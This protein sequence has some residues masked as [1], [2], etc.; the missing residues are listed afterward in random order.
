MKLA[1]RMNAFSASIFA[2][3]SACKQQKRSENGDLI[4]LSI[5]SPDLPPF[6]MEV[7]L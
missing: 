5:G 1:A 6:V 2:E 3:L 7:Y 4:D